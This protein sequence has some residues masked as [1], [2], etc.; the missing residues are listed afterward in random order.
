MRHDCSD[1]LYLARVSKAG[2][3]AYLGAVCGTPHLGKLLMGAQWRKRGPTL[4]KFLF[5]TPALYLSV[6]SIN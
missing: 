5:K 4:Q 6:T 3:L 2:Q 1:E